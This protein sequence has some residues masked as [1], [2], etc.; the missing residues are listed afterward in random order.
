MIDSCTSISCNTLL[1]HK[2][3]HYPILLEIK[4][5]DTTFSSSFK[6]LSMW[7]LHKDCRTFIEDC[8]NENVVGCPMLIL[9]TKLKNLKAKLKIW[10]K[11]VFGNIHESVSTAEANLNHI[12][13]Q[14]NL[15]GH[16]D[17][18][19]NLE[20]AAHIQLEEALKK[21]NIFWQEKARVNWHLDGDRNTKFYH[22]ITKIKNKTKLIS[23]II[24]DNEIIFEPSQIADHIVSY[25]KCL[26]S[27]NSFLQDSLLVEEVILELVDNQTNML[28]TKLPTSEEIKHA[29]FDMKKEGAPGPDGFGAWFFQEY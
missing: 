20:K 28:L 9:S 1:R 8:W 2:S 17:P 13:S 14:I 16:S 15:N 5:G 29:V 19:L 4:T 12:Q 6:F 23:S 10:N 24:N 18:L 26:F 7:S 25:Y 3:D 11:E 27:T 22:T 21:Q